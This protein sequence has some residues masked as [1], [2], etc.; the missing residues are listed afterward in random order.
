MKKNHFI[1]ITLVM[2]T[3]VY[4]LIMFKTY[5]FAPTGYDSL[6]HENVEIIAPRGG[7]GMAPE[8]S[9][10]CFEKG[11]A[12][13]ADIIEIDIRLTKDDVVVVCHDSDVK[14]TTD[15][16]G[17]IEEMTFEEVR[18]FRILDLNGKTFTRGS[19]H[20]FQA[21]GKS[22]S[23]TGT[24]TEIV[25]KNGYLLNAGSIA[26]IA[27]NNSGSVGTRAQFTF[28]FENVEFGIAKGATHSNFIIETFTGGAYGN[29][30]TVTFNDCIFNLT[31]DSS[32]GTVAPSKAITLFNLKESSGNKNY[33]N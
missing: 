27:F 21:Y 14:R 11:I 6:A 17:K 1:A 28:T 25:I 22:T 12:T 31:N 16:K 29:D 13:G 33:T 7:A 2:F 9:L 10:S 5:L 18:S 19:Y 24:S 8:N 32:I 20:M 15:G 26:L 23:S 30:A 3:V 4:T